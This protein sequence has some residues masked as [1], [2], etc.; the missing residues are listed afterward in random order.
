MAP[1][2]LGERVQKVVAVKRH[3]RVCKRANVA[4]QYGSALNTAQ[5]IRGWSADFGY[6]LSGFLAFTVD[7]ARSLEPTSFLVFRA[8]VAVR[9][10]ALSVS[11]ASRA[12]CAA[13]RWLARRF[14]SFAL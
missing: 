12:F 2:V 10:S 9:L 11:A 3:S 8:S 6:L 7:F 14:I 4:F 5:C 1:G 13:L